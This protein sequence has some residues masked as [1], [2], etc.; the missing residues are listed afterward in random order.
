[1]LSR[2]ASN[3]F[4][5]GRYVERI[6]YVARLIEVA[7]HMSMLPKQRESVLLVYFGDV[8]YQ[9]VGR[10]VATGAINTNRLLVNIS[11]ATDAFSICL[12]EN[13]RFVTGSAIHRSMPVFQREACLIMIKTLCSAFLFFPFPVVPVISRYRP[14]FRRMTGGAIYFQIVTMRVLRH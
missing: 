8:V 9:P 4:W 5:V 11:M 14:S 7:Q 10:T 3:L 6:D 12:G 1:M 13:Q 2:T